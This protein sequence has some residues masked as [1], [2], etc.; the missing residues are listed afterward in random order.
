MVENE[1]TYLSVPVP[2]DG[3]VIWGKGFDIDKVGRLPWLA[4]AELALTR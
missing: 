4:G 3:A 2:D 1:I